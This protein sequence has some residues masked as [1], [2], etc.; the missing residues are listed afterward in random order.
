MYQYPIAGVWSSDG[1]RVLHYLFIGS[2]NSVYLSRV[3]GLNHMPGIFM[4]IL[5]WQNS[6][7]SVVV[8]C[9]GILGFQASCLRVWVVVVGGGG[10]SGG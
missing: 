5:L 4:S 6:N 10:D 2:E 1:M 7:S 8:F 9:M 3:S